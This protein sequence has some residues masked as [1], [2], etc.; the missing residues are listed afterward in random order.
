MIS[1]EELLHMFVLAQP[2]TQAIFSNSSANAHVV[3][4]S[5][6]ID[7]ARFATRTW[8][9]IKAHPDGNLAVWRQDTFTVRF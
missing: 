5:R 3:L 9:Q 2:F 4:P 1:G 7:R 6:P 8:G